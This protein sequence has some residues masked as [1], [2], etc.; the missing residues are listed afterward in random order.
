MGGTLEV[1]RT[2]APS[3]ARGEE[4]DGAGNSHH[5]SAKSSTGIWR[6][7]LTVD[8]GGFRIANARARHAAKPCGVNVS[9]S[10]VINVA[11]TSASPQN[12]DAVLFKT[13]PILGCGDE[14]I[15]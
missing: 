12:S 14:L 13:A 6:R 5:Q 4:G 2:P 11:G 1:G 8:S 15:E 3:P 10:A 9:N 7:T